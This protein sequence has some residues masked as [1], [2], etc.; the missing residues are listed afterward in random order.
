[1]KRT[2]EGGYV[3][4][5]PGCKEGNGKTTYEIRSEFDSENAVI[6]LGWKGEG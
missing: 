1:M 5:P 2:K 3:Q 4:L 6:L